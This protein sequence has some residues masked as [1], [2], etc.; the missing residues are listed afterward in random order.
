[1][2]STEGVW[3][4]WRN[5]Y[6]NRR[7]SAALLLGFSSG[8]PLA[9]SGGTLQA[10]YAVAGVDIVA[11]GF[12]A[13]VGQPY[14][15]KFLWAPLLDRYV[16]GGLGRRRG[17]MLL[18]QVAIVGLLISMSALEPASAPLLLALLALAL[19]T[20]SATQDIAVDAWRTDVLKPEERGAGAAVGVAGYRLAMLVS[21]GL[22]LIVADFWGWREAYLLMAAA[23]GIGLLGTW[24]GPEPPVVHRPDSLRR[25]LADPFREFFSRPGAVGLLLL[26]VLYKLGDA[27]AGS[28]TLTFL[29]RGPGFSPAEV[30]GIYKLTVLLATLFGL[31]AG[32]AVLAQLGLY[33]SLLV[34]GILQAVSNLGF[35]LLA[36]S[37]KSYALMTV[38]VAFENLA[39]GMGTAAFVAF[40]MALCDHR[41]TATQFALLSALAAVGRIFVGPAAGVLVDAVG[42]AIFFLWTVVGAIPG[43]LLLWLMRRRLLALRAVEPAE[44][45]S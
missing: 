21:G 2:S 11:I 25:A 29:I 32:G 10:W 8:L 18:T 38:A 34:F 24:L 5:V 40:L 3:A 15:Y 43:L 42:W 27:F 37:G 26:I 17:W 20:A 31:F 39:G 28:L 30:G 45:S 44:G 9:L 1:L 16:P 41:Y 4:A 23:M 19:A 22:A 14:A 12:L 6:L 33:R 35:W 36:L 7:I 13:L